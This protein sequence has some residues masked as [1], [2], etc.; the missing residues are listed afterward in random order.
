MDLDDLV[1]GLVP[2]K[3][4]GLW[5]QCSAPY[6]D[7]VD[8]SVQAIEGASAEPPVGERTEPSPRIDE[9]EGGGSV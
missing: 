2:V 9:V 6:V 5:F 8:E 1:G 4:V 7:G 3:G